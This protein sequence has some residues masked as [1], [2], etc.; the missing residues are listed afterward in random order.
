M[1]IRCTAVRQASTGGFKSPPHPQGGQN[2]QED[3]EKDKQYREPAL[4]DSKIYHTDT[5]RQEAC[6]APRG[7]RG[8]Q[9]G[10]QDVQKQISH[11]VQRGWH[12]A[13]AV[14]GLILFLSFY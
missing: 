8:P 1:T 12:F 5:I 13:S 2:Q 6:S 11:T 4:L 3:F 7:P 9:M 10:R 14:Q